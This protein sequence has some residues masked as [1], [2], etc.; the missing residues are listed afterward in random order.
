MG[1]IQATNMDFTRDWKESLLIFYWASSQQ[2]R[3]I[4]AQLINSATYK[5]DSNDVLRMLLMMML[6][7]MVTTTTYNNNEVDA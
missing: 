4:S 1:K 5:D 7:I 6:M 2:F 3:P